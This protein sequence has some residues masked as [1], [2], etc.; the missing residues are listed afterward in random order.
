MKQMVHFPGFLL[1]KL[2]NDAYS[3]ALSDEI[4]CCTRDW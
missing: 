2:Y 4:C 1:N 3:D